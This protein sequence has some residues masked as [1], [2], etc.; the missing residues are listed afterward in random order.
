MLKGLPTTRRHL[1]NRVNKE[2][3][4][5]TLDEL[6]NIVLKNSYFYFLDI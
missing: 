3:K 4:T 1:G 6:A 2:V 5:D